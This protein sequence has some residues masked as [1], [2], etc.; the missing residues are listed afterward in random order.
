MAWVEGRPVP[1]TRFRAP[2][3]FRCPALLAIPALLCG[4]N[5]AGPAALSSG[6]GT[7]N[8]VINAT[9]DEQI[10]AMLVRDRYDDT[11][12]M[13]A[14]ASVTANIRVSASVGANFGVGPESSFEG[15][16]VPLSAGA[17][18]EENPTISYV[19][20]RGEQF[21]ERML[22]PI[23]LEQALL[24]SRAST[25]DTE[26]LRLVLR[27]ANG[28][29]NPL[30]APSPTAA[31]FEQFIDLYVRLREAGT[32][33]IV[34]SE[35]GGYKM[36]LHDYDAGEAAPQVRELLD[37][38]GIKADLAPGGLTVLPVRFSIGAPRPDGVDV[39]TPS[40]LDVMRAAATGIDVPR[41]HLDAGIARQPTARPPG[42]QFISI[43]SS[44]SR[45]GRAAVAVAYQGWWFF[46]DD[47][48]PASQQGFMILR[49]L[50]GMR[51][52]Q[53]GPT[54]QVPVLTVPVGR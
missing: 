50:I 51:L 10:L 48:D 53:A 37:T 44:R 30:Y 42:A 3:R 34:Q 43:H 36:L 12:G 41:E 19:P 4:C 33:D 49:T 40:V 29:A 26:V 24:L 54:Q 23:S 17:A 15:N 13:L 16:L 45:P 9:E 22:A 39:E 47:R 2:A 8:A 31:R 14:V 38:L 7:Y 18:Y 11:F 32:L 5:V 28:L 52:D 25:E 20:L 46:I 21:V 6:R 1:R 27:R 35:E